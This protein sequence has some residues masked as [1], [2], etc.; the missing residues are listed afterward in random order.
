MYKPRWLSVGDL[1]TI[2]REISNAEG[3]YG[4]GHEF[5]IIDIHFRGDEIFY[6]LR[7]HHQHLLGEVPLSDVTRV[8]VDT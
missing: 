5:R 6:D 2:N 8:E 7:D 1:V 4:A 3:T